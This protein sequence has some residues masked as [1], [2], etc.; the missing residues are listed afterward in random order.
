[1]AKLQQLAEG[2]LWSLEVSSVYMTSHLG[3]GGLEQFS[4]GFCLDYVLAKN[5]CS[6]GKTSFELLGKRIFIQVA[7]S[8][9]VLVVFN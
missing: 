1:M 6:T 4:P 8:A 9:V 2:I 7:H 3:H 5:Q